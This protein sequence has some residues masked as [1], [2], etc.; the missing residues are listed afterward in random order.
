MKNR[1]AIA[2]ALAALVVAVLASTSV[3]QAASHAVK[4]G[5]NKARAST[6]AGPLRANVSQP[7][8]GPR[9]PRGRRGPRGLT[10]PAGPAGPTGATGATG[11]TGP[12]G[13]AGTPA[14]V[15]KLGRVAQ[16]TG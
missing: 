5:V 3:G 12:Q 11:A 10:G 9:G 1:L 7:L 14:D 13:P 15:T 2:L 8:R 4:A 6:L 16:G